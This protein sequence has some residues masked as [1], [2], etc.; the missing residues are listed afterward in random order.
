[1]TSVLLIMLLGNQEVDWNLEV[2]T[3]QRT[4]LPSSFFCLLVL[5][6]SFFSKQAGLHGQIASPRMV[7]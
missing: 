2:A 5:P 4:T 1:M 3:T 6:T 7:C